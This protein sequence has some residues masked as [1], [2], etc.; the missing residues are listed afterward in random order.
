MFLERKSDTE[1]VSLFLKE[2]KV[3]AKN[4][5][6]K[7]QKRHFVCVSSFWHLLYFVEWFGIY[8]FLPDD[9]SSSND[10][11]DGKVNLLFLVI[12]SSNCKW[13]C[14]LCWYWWRNSWDIILMNNNK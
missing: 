10:D 12:I 2:K 7:P 14:S 4:F 9:Q 5:Q 3:R 8:N 11:D 6:K 1:K 13:W